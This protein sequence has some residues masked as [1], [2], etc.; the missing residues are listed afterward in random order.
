MYLMFSYF[1]VHACSY[2]RY[3]LSLY[4]IDHN[5]LKGSFG[6]SQDALLFL[7]FLTHC[8]QKSFVHCYGNLSTCQVKSDIKVPHR[9]LLSIYNH[10]SKLM[11]TRNPN[12]ASM[13]FSANSIDCPQKIEVPLPA[14]P[15]RPLQLVAILSQFLWLSQRKSFNVLQTRFVNTHKI[16]ALKDLQVDDSDV[17][18]AHE[19]ERISISKSK[20][21]PYEYRYCG[22]LTLDVSKKGTYP[23]LLFFER[24]L[25]HILV[26]VGKVY[27]QVLLEILFQLVKVALIPERQ[28]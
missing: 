23:F 11:S 18:T 15:P 8:L 21:A 7:A 22:T 26:I 10:V 25:L 27:E 4:R 2:T 17:D 6:S 9:Q 5:P 20:V 12:T 14:T 28:D 19:I 24:D 3:V 16:F 13:M 1:F